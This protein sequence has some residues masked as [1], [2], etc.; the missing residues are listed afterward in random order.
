MS[1]I[2]DIQHALSER[3]IA[4][5]VGIRHDEARM[6]FPL[7]KNTVDTFEEFLDII[8]AYYN[9]HFAACISG[10]GRLAPWEAQERA[11]EALEREYRRRDRNS[12]IVAAF[13][14]AHDGA[15]AGLR[16][17]L[18]TIAESLKTESVDRYTRSVFDRYVA[19]NSWDDKV[20]IIRQFIARCGINF[21]SSIRTDQPERYARDYRDLLSAYNEGLRR[22]SAVCRR[23]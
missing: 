3:V 23:L 12:D 10:G 6:R 9:Y 21:P 5:N 18:D 15:N 8:G 7:R 11:K 20:D 19:P 4:Q 17:L 22:T 1:A 13:N 2:D 14:D 16:G